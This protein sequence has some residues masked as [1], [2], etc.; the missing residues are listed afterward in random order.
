MPQIQLRAY[1]RNLSSKGATH[2]LR[3]GGNAP[4]VIYGK[5]IE[6]TPI[7]F[8][9]KEFLKAIS[10]PAGLNVIFDLRLQQKEMEKPI[11][12]MVKEI[13]REVISYDI[14]HV[15]F[16]AI[17]LEETISVLVPLKLIGTAKGMA[18]GGVL[19]QNLHQVEVECLPVA[20]PQF[21]ELDVTCLDIGDSLFAQDLILP[22]GVSLVTEGITALVTL[23]P[24]LKEE[25]PAEAAAPAVE[26]VPAPGKAPAGA[27]VKESQEE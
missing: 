1:I 26:P 3:R 11:T 25:A 22:E 10:Q 8:E 23:V 13:Q 15:D 18:E 5:N 7:F 21:L 19:Q 12:C 24:P 2:E 4:G 6:P 9:K 16:H 14:L 20:I 17:S 27:E